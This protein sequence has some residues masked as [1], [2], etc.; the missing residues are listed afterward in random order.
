LLSFNQIQGVKNPVLDMVKTHALGNL[1][2][3]LTCAHERWQYASFSASAPPFLASVL[4]SIMACHTHEALLNTSWQYADF[5][6]PSPYF[7]LM[8]TENFASQ[9]LLE[10]SIMCACSHEINMYSNHSMQKNTAKWKQAI[11]FEMEPIVF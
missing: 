5:C 1:L 10:P 6:L 3:N 2:H 4:P 9:L 7:K 11:A 8:L